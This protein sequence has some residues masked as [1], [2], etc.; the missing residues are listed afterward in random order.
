MVVELTVPM[1]PDDVVR[2]CARVEALLRAAAEVRVEVRGTDVAVLGAL[3]RMRLCARRLGGRLEVSGADLALVEVTGL[4]EVLQ[5]RRQPEAREQRGVEE[6]VDVGD[7][8][9]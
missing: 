3:A 4:S 2:T 1:T 8:S 9:P 6:V 7:P 5:V